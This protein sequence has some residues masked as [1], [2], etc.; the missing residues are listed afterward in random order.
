M[1]RAKPDNIIFD[2]IAI[3]GV[4]LIGGSL[5]MAA[6]K[7]RLTRRV[8][9]IGRSEQ[10]LMRAKIL[11]A[12]DDYSLDFQ[13]GASE[14]DLVIICTPVRTVVPTLERMSPYLKQGA[15]VTDVGSTKC[16]IVKQAEQVMP[17][18]NCFI[19]GHPMAGSEE[20]GVEGAFPDMFLGATYVLTPTDETGLDTLGRMTAFAEGIGARVEVMNPEE[21]DKAV[22]IISHLPHVMSAALLHAAVGSK[23]SSGKALRLAAGSFRDLTRISD[24][25]PEIWRDICLTNRSSLVHAVGELQGALADFK[26]AL[27]SGDE[28]AIMRFFEEAGKIRQLHLRMKQ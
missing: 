14:A 20:S 12:I 8:I 25:P 27:M 3:A 9:G 2:T 24:S 1:P 28:A 11:G 18:G 23:P 4:G 6:K 10:K 7:N 16:E 15:V 19:G 22:A 5:G 13:R 17:H 21:H 26:M